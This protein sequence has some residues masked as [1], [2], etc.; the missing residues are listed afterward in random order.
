MSVE[1]IALHRY[2][3][4]LEKIRD[5]T[6]IYKITQKGKEMQYG[7][8]SFYS[9]ISSNIPLIKKRIEKEVL[10]ENITKS[11]N[12][13]VKTPEIQKLKQQEIRGKKI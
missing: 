4:E 9:K 5:E 11:G 3:A 13:L 1:M 12:Q 2:I 10:E 6:I 7:L 8:D